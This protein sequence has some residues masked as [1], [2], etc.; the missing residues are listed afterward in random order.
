MKK[1]FLATVAIVIAAPA[2]AADLGARPITKAPVMG[3]PGYSWSGCYIGVQGGWGSMRSKN[4]FSNSG[5]PPF[6]PEGNTDGDGGIFGGHLGCNW[7]SSQ[8]VFGLEGDGEWSGIKG[9][10]GN[11]GGDT[12]ELS[13]RWL[14][15]FR[16]RLGMAFGNSLLYATGGVAFMGA[17]SSVLDPGEGESL[18]KTLTGWT[19]GAGWEY[20]FAPNFSARV[21]YRFTSFGTED[22]RFPVNGYT[23]RHNDIDIH[24]VRVGLTYR[25]GGPMFARY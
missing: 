15:S 19:V 11:V 5:L 4:S 2:L 8:W 17:R 13:A 20:G 21:E 23:E 14:A 25:F 3:A 6:T 7:Q 9:D 1:F 22:F 24:A 18:R 16:G 12:N 10:D